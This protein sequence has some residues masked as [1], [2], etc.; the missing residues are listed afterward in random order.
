MLELGCNSEP[1]RLPM[2]EERRFLEDGDQATLRAYCQQQGL[3]RIGFGECTGT[4]AYP[5]WLRG[6]RC[7]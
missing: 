1:V 3:P 4:I 5:A 2:G 6:L 7:R